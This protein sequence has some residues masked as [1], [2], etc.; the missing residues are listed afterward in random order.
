MKSKLLIYVL[1]LILLVAGGCASKRGLAQDQVTTRYA[2]GN[3]EKV[4]K[5]AEAIKKISLKSLHVL[6]IDGTGVVEEL[7]F[8]E[9]PH[10]YAEQPESRDHLIES[11]Y[12]NQL[13]LRSFIKSLPQKAQ[14]RVS[15]KK[16]SAQALDSLIRAEKFDVV[17]TA[18]Q[19]S[20]DY[21]FRYAGLN[22][23]KKETQKPQGIQS[24]YTTKILHAGGAG[25][26]DTRQAGHIDAYTVGG[27]FEFSSDN[28][29]PPLLTRTI[30]YRTH[31]NLQWT[32]PI[33]KTDK[34]QQI[35]QEGI[36]VDGLHH[37]EIVFSEAA[38]Q[39]GKNLARIFR[40]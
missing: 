28:R 7:P 25:H 4:W 19:I 31:W 13:V 24:G 27:A 21:Q 17:I 20:F 1:L 30:T 23:L 11:R 2:T 8:S 38:Q 32:D 36:L 34:S 14:V 12:Y 22:I 33:R 37:A 26:P 40:W 6:V 29:Q 15:A 16:W 35:K 5:G 3:Q 39:A 18:Q 10:V 9:P